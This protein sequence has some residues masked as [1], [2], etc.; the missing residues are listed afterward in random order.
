MRSPGGWERQRA[1][2]GRGDVRRSEGWESSKDGRNGAQTRTEEAEGKLHKRALWRDGVWGMRRLGGNPC[3]GRAS[4]RSVFLYGFHSVGLRSPIRG[5]Q[6][7]MVEG[8]F[9][10]EVG[11]A[12]DTQ[13]DLT[14]NKFVVELG[15]S[16]LSRCTK[17]ALSG[18]YHPKCH[19]LTQI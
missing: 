6:L 9:S 15:I 14:S 19:L 16:E 4:T 12:K 17:H 3:Q 18:R 13:A 8:L 1:L 11:I 7:G 5:S 2:L 10:Y